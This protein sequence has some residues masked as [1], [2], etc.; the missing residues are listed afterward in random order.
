[1]IFAVCD[2]LLVKNRKQLLEILERDIDQ[3]IGE[4]QHGCF[5]VN[6]KGPMGSDDALKADEPHKL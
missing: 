4:K 3:L 2:W 1:V 5:V 6:L